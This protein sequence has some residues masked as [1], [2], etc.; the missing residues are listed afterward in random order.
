MGAIP[1]RWAFN[2][3]IIDGQYVAT[4]SAAASNRPQTPTV[5]V[6]LGDLS[7]QEIRR[8]AVCIKVPTNRSD[9][10]AEMIAKIVLAVDAR[11]SA[12][13]TPTVD[14]TPDHHG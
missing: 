5:T 6:P 14:P 9:S 10:N 7:R 11:S 4:V 3:D 2:V 8:A 13:P 1:A 12:V